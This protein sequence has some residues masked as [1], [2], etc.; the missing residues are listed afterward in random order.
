MEQ[1]QYREVVVDDPY[2]EM[3]TGPGAATRSFTLAS[4]ASRSR[5]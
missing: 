4:A 3:H 1:E 2:I 5:F